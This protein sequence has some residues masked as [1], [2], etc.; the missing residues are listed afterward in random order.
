MI[1]IRGEAMS[2][3]V[4]LDFTSGFLQ[5]V[6]VIDKN[7]PM[8]K[9]A[10]DLTK[11]G[12]HQLGGWA[13]DQEKQF[14][15]KVS[16]A[17]GLVNKSAALAQAIIEHPMAVLTLS[18]NEVIEEL[19]SV[20]AMLASGG[21]AGVA[22]LMSL[23]AGGITN[24]I[25]GAGAGYNEARDKALAAGKTEAEAHAAGQ[26]SALAAGA[27]QAVLGTFA[28]SPLI[29]KGFGAPGTIGTA[30]KREV[31]TEIPEEF[32]QTGFADY[33]GTGSFDMNNALTAAVIAPVIAGTS[34]TAIGT[35]VSVA[36]SGDAATEM[37]NAVDPQNSSQIINQVNTALQSSSSI[38]DAGNKITSS[39]QEIGF[40]P[41]QAVSIANTVATEQFVNNINDIA[42]EGSRFSID[43]INRLIGATANGNPVT[44]GDYIGAT[45][46]GK[47]EQMFVTPDLVIGTKN[48]GNILT[49]GDVSGALI[50]TNLGTET[51]T[52]TNSDT[53]TKT[54][55]TVSQNPETNTT[56][57]TKVETNPNTNV[58]TESNVTT[59]PNSVVATDTVVNP[60]TNTQVDINSKVDTN[61]ATAT[62]VVT[63]TITNVKTNIDLEDDI[64]TLVAGGMSPFDAMKVVTENVKNAAKRGTDQSKRGAGSGGGMGV[65]MF[66][67]E[68]SGFQH[69][70]LFTRGPRAQFES[71]LEAFLRQMQ[72]AEPEPAPQAQPT[73][74]FS[75]G[76]PSDIDEILA[77]ESG[78]IPTDVIPSGIGTSFRMPSVFGGM[79]AGG[80]A[81]AAG[82]PLTIA[83]GKI[84]RDYRQG[85]AVEGPGDGQSDDI[86]AMLA[87]GE[88]VIDAEIVAALG[89]GSNKAG[90]E[91]LDK[92]REEIRRHKRGGSLNEIPPQS[93]SPLQYLAAAKKKVSK[94]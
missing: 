1:L 63:N 64:A 22:R 17:E 81:L 35:A 39:L 54:T 44:L 47:G 5:S 43:N 92:F 91:L 53:G 74:Y 88:Y 45:L 71:P 69:G 75:Y 21:A 52:E 49:V 29:K 2:E 41:E 50:S 6:E 14:I 48:D 67:E 94:R 60:N 82:G 8:V 51:K 68:D 30:V 80:P 56:T 57:E 79:K 18:A 25:E 42:P 62:A 13:L 11:V 65:P 90:A 27:T 73:E 15:Q 32:A 66:G 3:R 20:L 89:N 23:G 70:S 40:S 38:Q 28:E 26:K 16:D 4:G 36:R 72:S 10:K 9:L 12:E 87:D 37:I 19:P 24:Y 77:Q 33:F 55:T 83:A 59:N 34:V 61:T 46:T 84:R 85:D 31:T 58:T 93:K 86:P 78:V 76:T 7:S